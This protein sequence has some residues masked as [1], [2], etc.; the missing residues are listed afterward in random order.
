[1][2]D[3]VKRADYPDGF[4]R[5][6]GAALALNGKD[7]FVELPKDVADMRACT[8][9]VEF[10]WNGGVNGARLFEFANPNGDAVWFSP[11][12]NG[13]LVFA[14]R[15]G[16]KTEALI[17]QGLQPGL[18]TSVQISLDRKNAALFVN[19]KKVAENNALT[20]SPDSI[21]ATQCYLGRGLTSGFYGGLIGRFTIHSAALREPA[22][23]GANPAP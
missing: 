3:L 23:S 17:A 9:T 21:R 6:G 4:T 2:A 7:Q 16:A 20:L 11:W 22:V 12:E 8:Y 18:W 5:T 19:G 10:K 15:R 1:V 13:K 14:V